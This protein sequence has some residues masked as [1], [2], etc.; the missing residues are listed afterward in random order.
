MEIRRL[1]RAGQRGGPD[2]RRAGWRRDRAASPFLRGE[3]AFFRQLFG[4]HK[5]GQ[6][7]AGRYGFDRHE[8]LPLRN[9]IGSV[10]EYLGKY[11]GKIGVGRHILRVCRE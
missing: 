2:W 7:I 4:R 9:G 1:E 6:H 8:L 11:I 10:V 3:W 5:D